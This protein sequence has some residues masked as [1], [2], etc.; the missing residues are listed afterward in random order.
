MVCQVHVRATALLVA[1][2]HFNSSLH[3]TSRVVY[4]TGGGANAIGMRFAAY[5]ELI[6][7]ATM[8][9]SVTSPLILIGLGRSS[10]S[11]RN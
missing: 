8:L 9:I 1:R 2:Q 5:L 7:N 10:D 3:T 11:T 4:R 6:D